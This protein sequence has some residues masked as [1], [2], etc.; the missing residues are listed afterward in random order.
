MIPAFDYTPTHVY[1]LLALTN[2]WAGNIGIIFIFGEVNVLAEVAFHLNSRYTLLRE[3]LEQKSRK[4][5]QRVKRKGI[6]R[7]FQLALIE[8]IQRNIE[9]NEFAAEFQAQFSYRIFVLFSFAAAILCVVMFK[10]YTVR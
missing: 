7:D 4:L 1:V 6:A 3:D 5:L 10:I 2:V 8:T 9:L